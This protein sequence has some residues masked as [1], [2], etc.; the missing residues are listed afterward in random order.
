MTTTVCGTIFTKNEFHPIFTALKNTSITYFLG[1]ETPPPAVDICDTQDYMEYRVCGNVTITKGNAEQKLEKSYR[2]TKKNTYV[3][4]ECNDSPGNLT[5][6][7][8]RPL[9]EFE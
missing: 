8:R 7:W 9:K 5:L 1:R 6:T 4:I 3:H 2:V